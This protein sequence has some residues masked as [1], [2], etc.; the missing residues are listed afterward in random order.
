MFLSAISPAAVT[1]IALAAL[2]SVQA[3]F[4]APFDSNYTTDKNITAQQVEIIAPL[5]A[6][7]TTPASIYPENECTNSSRVAKG[8]NESNKIWGIK[9]LGTMSAIVS[10]LTHESDS[11]RAN[12]NHNPAPGFPGQGSMSNTSL[13]R[14]K[15]V[16][17][18]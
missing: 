11:Y 3:M 15:E 10:L 13:P 17:L 12:I 8:I 7:C 6:S 14:A 18:I 1:V 5:T 16:R 2:G 9:S 4:L